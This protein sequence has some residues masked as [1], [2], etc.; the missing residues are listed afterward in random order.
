M[1]LDHT[2]TC[3]PGLFGDITPAPPIV[4]PT[5]SVAPPPT[6]PGNQL[7]CEYNNCTT[8]TTNCYHGY[9]NCSEHGADPA[10]Y[11]CAV[12]ATRNPSGLY[13]LQ[14]KGCEV[15][16]NL[17][18]HSLGAGQTNC[19]LDT[20]S[21]SN[22]ISCYCDTV[23]CNNASNLVFTDASRFIGV[24]PDVRCESAGCSHS[25]VISNGAPRCLCRQGYALDADS[26]T[27][28]GEPCIQSSIVFCLGQ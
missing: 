22:Q 19:L 6:V 7:V 2:C 18:I 1:D 26:T 16:A 21:S 15:T 11:F 23:F 17:T 27:C 20:A 3:I 12:H 10:D 14:S 24:D 28:V 8:S 4:L 13:E 5:P 9:Q 25:C